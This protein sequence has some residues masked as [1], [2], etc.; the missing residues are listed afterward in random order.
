MDANSRLLAL[1]QSRRRLCHASI[2]ALGLVAAL[3]ATAWAKGRSVGGQS[4]PTVR[5][6]RVAE[7]T[8]EAVPPD[9]IGGEKA[10]DKKDYAQAEKLLT[11][12]SSTNPNHYSV[13]FDLGELYSLTHRNAQAKA[14][15]KKNV[16]NNP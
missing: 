11:S 10:L 3:T 9:V 7:T 5:H 8:A 1:A 4:K 12:A 15:Y 13:W 2:G 16:E 6:H 14:A